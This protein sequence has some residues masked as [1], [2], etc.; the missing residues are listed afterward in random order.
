MRTRCSASSRSSA[1]RVSRGL[2]RLLQRLKF[3]G[4]L[5]ELAFDL[6]APSGD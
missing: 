1:A 6:G 3:K 2:A 5:I 4:A